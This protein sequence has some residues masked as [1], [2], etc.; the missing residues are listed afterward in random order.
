[1][2]QEGEIIID[3][4]F[5]AETALSHSPKRPGGFDYYLTI[6][7]KAERIYSGA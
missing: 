1:M 6:K 5:T 2:N 7:E 4:L 3:L